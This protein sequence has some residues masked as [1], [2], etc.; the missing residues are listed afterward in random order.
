MKKEIA[1][2]MLMC[3]SVSIMSSCIT[4]RRLFF[5]EQAV[6][7]VS[8]NSIEDNGQFILKVAPSVLNLKEKKLILEKDSLSENMKIYISTILRECHSSQ[9]T[10][11]AVSQDIIISKDL[12]TNRSLEANCMYHF[13]VETDRW[14]CSYVDVPS[15]YIPFMDEPC[16]FYRKVYV[17]K[18]RNRLI[19]KDLFDD[20][21][22]LYVI[23]GRDNQTDFSTTSVWDPSDFPSLITTSN[24]IREKIDPISYD[25]A[26]HK[27]INQINRL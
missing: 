3:L 8:D 11:I 25:I 10:L 20:I 15:G 12:K 22:V 21:S 9:D 23:Q 16:A 4:Q 24:Y 7:R 6:I 1:Q 26:K 18:R 19:I 13:D 2:F 14:I 5:S 27:Y 17:T